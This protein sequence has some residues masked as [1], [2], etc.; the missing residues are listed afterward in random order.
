MYK[1][2]GI[3]GRYDTERKMYMP[4]ESYNSWN[5]VVKRNNIRLDLCSLKVDSSEALE[6]FIDSPSQPSSNIDD[7]SFEE[8]QQDEEEKKE[9]E[10]VGVEAVEEFHDSEVMSVGSYESAAEYAF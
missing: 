7:A 3:E 6:H 9:E 4:P 10:E 5:D 8:A 2:T 1:L